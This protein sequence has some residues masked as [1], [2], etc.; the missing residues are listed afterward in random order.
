MARQL[1]ALLLCDLQLL[2]QLLQLLLPADAGCRK[3]EIYTYLPGLQFLYQRLQ[4]LLPAGPSVKL[5]RESD[6][7]RASYG[8]QGTVKALP[9]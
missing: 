3:S 2:H 6:K 4:P 9:E 1:L 7:C 5:L 8:Q